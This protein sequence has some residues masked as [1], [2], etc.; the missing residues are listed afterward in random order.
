MEALVLAGGRTSKLPVSRK[1]DLPIGDRTMVDYVIAAL[2]AVPAVQNVTVA[3]DEA[4]SLIDNL[5]GAIAQLSAGPDDLVLI[6]SCDIPFLT[7]EAVLDFLARCEPGHDFYYPI[8]RKES[9]DRRF[10]GVQ[11]TYVRLREGVF[12]G[13]NLVLVRAAILPPLADRLQR[14]FANRKSPVKLSRELGFGVA[15]QLVLSALLRTLSVSALERRVSRS[16]D[17]RAKAV[18]SEYAE[19]GTDIDKESDLELLQRFW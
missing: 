6:A 17:I 11:R 14:L 18:Y 12:T 8:V 4:D 16:F 5:L 1:A 7:P 10:A 2:E 19:I 9:C 3:R 13:G 15:V